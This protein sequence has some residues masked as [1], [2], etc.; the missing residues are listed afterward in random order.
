MSEQPNTGAH[1]ALA[2]ADLDRLAAPRGE[3][4]P[5]LDTLRDGGPIWFAAALTLL[6]GAVALLSVLL[7][8][9]ARA[10]L[11]FSLPLPFGMYHWSRTLTSVF[12]L[13]LIYLSFQL[14]RR[15]RVAWEL[16]V[17]G[18]ILTAAVHLGRGH[19]WLTAFVPLVTAGWLLAWRKRFTVHSE[20]Q[21]IRRGLL[22]MALSLLVALAYGTLGFWLLDRRDFGQDF[23]L[24]S[25]LLQTLRQFSLQGNADLAPHTRY[26]RWFLESLGVLGASAIGLAAFSL[27]RPVAYRLATLPRQRA[28]MQSLLEQYGGTGLD[29]FKLGAGLSYFFSPNERAAIAYRVSAGVAVALGDPAGAPDELEPLL[30]AF[31]RYCTENGWSVALDEVSPRLLPLCYRA[32]LRSFKL[33]EEAMV[34]LNGFVTYT[35]RHKQFRNIRNKFE[36]D[37]Y[38]TARRLPP[39]EPGLID[40]LEEVSRDWLAL[41][42]HRERGFTLGQFQRAYIGACPLFI[43]LDAA[44][45]VVAFANEIPSYRPGDATIDLMRHRR[46]APHGTMDF[47]FVRL[48]ADLQARGYRTFDLGLAPLAGVGDKPSD[49]LGERLAHRLA[50]RASRFFSYKGLRDYKAKY[51]PT[52]ESRYLLYQGGPPGLIKTALAILRLAEP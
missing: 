8:R 25:A 42:G 2:D 1:P 20:P 43:V 11:F 48:L 3:P 24:G 22:F 26:A 15:Q 49:P 31:V 33:G 18:S 32:G 34:D 27:F 21:S 6:N 35:L 12:G 28:A 17:A 30:R 40:Q 52:W 45:R 9:M 38:T 51:D 14:L 50:E 44:G 23:R 47:L 16:A 5:L 29:Y 19:P 39:H 36:R 37:G 10:A 46:D 7:I 4:R 13:L 41:P